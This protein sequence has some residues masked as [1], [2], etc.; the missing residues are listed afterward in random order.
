MKPV[1]GK[2]LTVEA[3]V[4]ESSVVPQLVE[5]LPSPV[6]P[7]ERLL[8]LDV[9]RG[10]AM[11]GVILSNFND[12]Y[13]A[14][15]TP[16][17]PSDAVFFWIQAW[18]IQNR[19]YTLLAFLF[20]VGFAIQ[21]LRAE[22]RGRNLRTIYLRR[23]G[24]LLLIGLIHGVFIWDGDILA[25]YALAGAALFLFRKLSTRRL[26]IAV[27]AVQVLARY[28]VSLLLRAF[29]AT[30]PGPVY[31]IADPGAIY[32]H[33]DYSQIL[34]LQFQ[35]TVNALAALPFALYWSVLALMLVGLAVGR[36]GILR[37]LAERRR[38]LYRTLLIAVVCLPIGLYFALR[39]P[40]W[41]PQLT[42]WPMSIH[43]PNFW[44]PRFA[45]IFVP[46]FLAQWSQ[47]AIYACLYVLRHPDARIN[48]WLA[49]IGRM[50]LTTYL[51]QSVVGVL[52]FY[53]YGLGLY[54][55]VPYTPMFFL[56]VTIFALQIVASTWWLQRFQ[57]GPVEWLW[58]SLTYG[59][60]MSL[61]RVVLP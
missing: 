40:Q 6:A 46:N 32:A 52:I 33:G 41:W 61:R 19:F 35:K 34:Q 2:I 29:G 17:S 12:S 49:A 59:R 16:R 15:G 24:A 45:L 23:V 25:T 8:T 56:A 10:L 37:N 22:E 43:D 18:L 21:I 38:V 47:A 44:H 9:L 54:G 13:G 30:P 26:L 1:V 55:R 3:P 28:V 20:G 50:A 31:S 57:F 51:T 4:D 60:R 14:F 7:E 27:V 36:S 58:R 42:R 48:R 53:G 5:R 11:F 39:L